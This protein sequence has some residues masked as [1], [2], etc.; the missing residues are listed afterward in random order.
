MLRQRTNRRAKVRRKPRPEP[1]AIASGR[2]KEFHCPGCKK[3]QDGLTRV[4]CFNTGAPPPSVPGVCS[5]CG[6]PLIFEWRTDR[7]WP[8]RMNAKEAEGLDWKSRLIIAR[9]AERFSRA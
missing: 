5:N 9:F 7:Y 4:G 2:V 6:I 8:R 1:I 3:R